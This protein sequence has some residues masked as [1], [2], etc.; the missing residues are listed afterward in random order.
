MNGFYTKPGPLNT[1]WG[2]VFKFTVFE[3]AAAPLS[4]CCYP[5]HRALQSG[6]KSPKLGSIGQPLD[7]RLE[8]Y[9]VSNRE[10]PQRLNFECP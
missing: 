4:E 7:V 8:P 3:T 2:A 1:C 6:K 5:D 10:Y 9:G